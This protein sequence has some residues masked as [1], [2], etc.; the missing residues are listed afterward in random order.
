MLRRLWR[1][2]CRRQME[3]Y[4]ACYLGALALANGSAIPWAA[5]A[6]ACV[7]VLACAALALGGAAGRAR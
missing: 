3:V 6:P 1:L 2:L 4:A 7:L 5:L